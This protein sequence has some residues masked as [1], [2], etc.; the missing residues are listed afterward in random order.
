MVCLGA[1]SGLFGSCGPFTDVA[2]DSF[3][4]FVQ[5]VFYLG[6]TT[7]TTAT[8]YDPT[9]NV[10]RLQMAAFLSRTVDGVLKRNS[11]RSALTEFWTTQNSSVVGLTTVGSAPFAVKSDGVD[12]W[13][14]GSGDATVS[15]VRGSDGK[16]L[17][18]WTGAPT[19][20]AA[21]S[22]MGAV[23]VAGYDTVGK[24]YRIDPSQPAGVVTTVANN[25]PQFPQAI[26]YD[27][28]RIWTANSTGSVSIVAPG[29]TIPWAVA[30]VTAGTSL[31]GIVYDGTRIWVSNQAAGTLLKLD[32]NGA[33]LQTVTVGGQPQNPVFD[34][35]N[36]WFQATAPSRSRSC[37]LPTAWSWRR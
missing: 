19:A 33:N 14:A 26:A 37:A 36:I 12:V 6:V 5:E 11:R 2:A 32:A 23:F 8:T 17:E 16:L 28:T 21:L 30:N 18:T 20:R 13:A 24:I 27:G 10:T 15:R 3:C 1:A 35:T 4:A 22:A 31:A 34:G 7:G 25:L 29:P 9:T